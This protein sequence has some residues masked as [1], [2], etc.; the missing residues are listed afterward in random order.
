MN[1]ALNVK[2]LAPP[3]GALGRGL[4]GQSSFNFNYKVNFKDFL[5]QSVC[6][7]SQMKDTKHIRRDFHYVGWVMPRGWDFGALGAQVV[8]KKYFSNMVMWLIKSMGMMSRMQVTF[9][10]YGQTG[11]LGA[12]SKGQISLTCQFQRFLYQTLCVCIHK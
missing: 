9:S 11:D 6:V 4:K 5:F 1:G 7:F 10:S 12:R 2:K 3:P 8:K